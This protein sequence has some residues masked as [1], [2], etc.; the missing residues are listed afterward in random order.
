MPNRPRYSPKYWMERS[1]DLLARK[2][3]AIDFGSTHIK[4]LVAEESFGKVRVFNHVLVDLQGEG[5]LS[6]EEINKHLQ[7]LI[8][9]LG[10]HP[11]AVSLPQHLAL[12]HLLDL[13]RVGERDIQRM[14]EQKTVS[15]SGL[16]ESSII[17]DFRPLRPFG[18]YQNPYWITYT[19]E[20]EVQNQMRRLSTEEEET[21]F[22]EVTAVANALIAA[23]LDL[24]PPA[25]RA[26]LVDLGATSTVLAIVDQGQGIFATSFPIGGES[27]TG[28]IASLKKCTFE[29]AELVKRS[30]NLFEGPA[31]MNEF[32]TVI[33]IWRQDLNR[34]L[35]EWEEENPELVS[36]ADSTRLVLSGGGARQPGLMDYLKKHLP[37]E[38]EFWPEAPGSESGWPMERFAA[39][40]GLVVQSLKKKVPSA[41]LLPGALRVAKQRQQQLVRSNLV[42]FVLLLVLA[43][44]L[45]AG[46]GQKFL[47]YQTRHRQAEDTELALKKVQSVQLLLQQQE[48]EFERV[49][50]VLRRQWETLGILK[51]LEVFQ[52]VRERKDLWLMVLADQPSYFEGTSF[53]AADTN[54]SG[55]FDFLAFTNRFEPKPGFIAELAFSERAGDRQSQLLELVT[56]LKKERIF[57]NVDTLPA[58]LRNTN[59]IDPKLMPADRSVALSIE[60]S[61]EELELPSMLTN[62]P[63]V[64]RNF[65]KKRR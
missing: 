25:G 54:L 41:S 35:R 8:G 29:E 11:V 33:E 16:S 22:C 36:G 34:L 39:A 13:P 19:R 60:L 9:T 53:R 6:M 50:P 56:D 26:I 65:K 47:Q 37:Y 32:R 3:I 28:A 55:P 14:I 17:Y 45:L 31:E 40:Y 59:L 63:A 1:R 23:Y 15:L 52:K 43:V 46:F 42:T 4:I 61:Q 2:L 58:N 5:L 48:R 49:R 57:S 18:K 62:A 21:L 12:S 20:Q 51:T 38:V 64:L 44:L 30:H 7:Q 24:T 10:G 27:F